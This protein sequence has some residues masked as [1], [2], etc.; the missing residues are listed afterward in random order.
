MIEK[1]D[2]SLSAIAQN[3]GNTSGTSLAIIVALGL[4]VGTLIST[5][6]S[7]VTR[8]TILD[9]EAREEVGYGYFLPIGKCWSCGTTLALWQQI[10]LLSF[11]FLRRKCLHCS[12]GI[13]WRYPLTEALTAT[14]LLVCLLRWSELKIGVGFFVFFSGIILALSITL[15]GNIL[16]SSVTFVLSLLGLLASALDFGQLTPKD[17]IL[18]A[19]L[20]YAI[21]YVY[22]KANATMNPHLQRVQEA[23]LLL[24]ASIGSWLGPA[25]AF[26][27]MMVAVAII[28]IS[29]AVLKS[30][31]LA[32]DY[33]IAL[34]GFVAFVRIVFG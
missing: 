11:I 32:F 21:P 22:N 20:G 9:E 27:M 15:R 25:I 31:P 17:A 14:L 5:L 33:Q 8:L 6:G 23:Y 1:F 18:G 10:P 4:M 34:V 3:F 7:R 16:P 13:S 2:A 29:R 28:L 12:A 26:E 24:F 30:H 19:A